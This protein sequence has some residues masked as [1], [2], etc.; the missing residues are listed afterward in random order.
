MA[1]LFWLDDAYFQFLFDYQSCLVGYVHDGVTDGV[2]IFVTGHDGCPIEV[3]TSKSAL[4]NS[5]TT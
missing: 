4:D 1:I 3:P 2:G 5:K